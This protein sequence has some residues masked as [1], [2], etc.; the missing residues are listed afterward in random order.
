VIKKALTWIGEKIAQGIS[1]AA[2]FGGMSLIL[3]FVDA[4]KPATAPTHKPVLTTDTVCMSIEEHKA[5]HPDAWREKKS[6]YYADMDGT[7]HEISW[8]DSFK[9][10][11][12]PRGY[13]CEGTF[14]KDGKIDGWP[15]PKFNPFV[16]GTR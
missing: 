14:R 16:G 7:I 6:G 4:G 11:V 1:L 12:E 3:H 8:E 2:I 5:A 9:R 10:F 15:L 13:I